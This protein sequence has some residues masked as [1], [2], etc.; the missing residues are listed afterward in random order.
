MACQITSL[1]E[2]TPTYCTLIWS[3]TWMHSKVVSEIAWFVKYLIATIDQTLKLFLHPLSLRI[4]DFNYLV[5][6]WKVTQFIIRLFFNLLI[7]R[8]RHLVLDRIFCWSIVAARFDLLFLTFLI[9][10]R[11][12]MFDLRLV[13]LGKFIFNKFF[14]CL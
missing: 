14:Q 4:V 10:I 11:V 8:I 5:A 1:G 13:Y 2:V 9:M 3:F 7:T 6:T 12:I